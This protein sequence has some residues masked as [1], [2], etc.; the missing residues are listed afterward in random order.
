MSESHLCHCSQS[1]RLISWWLLP[2]QGAHYI[3]LQSFSESWKLL[4]CP[5]NR[6]FSLQKIYLGLFLHVA[7]PLFVCQSVI[8][9]YWTM[10]SALYLYWKIGTEAAF[11]LNLPA[12]SLLCWKMAKLQS[13]AVGFDLALNCWLISHSLV[14]VQQRYQ[15]MEKWEETGALFTSGA[16]I[17]SRTE[18][19]QNKSS[20][21]GQL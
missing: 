20:Q 6:D 17:F 8:C 13:G 7:N 5:S 15:G 21:A 10:I 4:P 16:L 12:G 14:V 11:C 1:R 3:F 19:L 9:L 2:S 18:C